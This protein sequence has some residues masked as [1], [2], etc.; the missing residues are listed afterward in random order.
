MVVADYGGG[1][2]GGAVLLLLLMWRGWAGPVSL[3]SSLSLSHYPRG[4]PPHP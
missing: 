2:G 4:R 1:S 3:V